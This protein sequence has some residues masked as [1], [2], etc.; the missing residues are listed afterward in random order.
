M[1]T[2]NPVSSTITHQTVEHAVSLAITGAPHVSDGALTIAPTLA[3]LVYRRTN[4]EPVTWTAHLSGPRVL[5]GTPTQDATDVQTV[6]FAPDLGDTP[7]W[8]ADL[9]MQH[10]PADPNMIVAEWVFDAWTAE[11]AG[12]SGEQLTAV[13]AVARAA[14][15]LHE[16]LHAANIDLSPELDTLGDAAAEAAFGRFAE[17]AQGRDAPADL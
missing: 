12:L 6:T 16:R 9:A 10:T 4:R 3:S 14:E 5:G 11:T 17:R 15:N 13:G 1:N 7:Q 2:P 8:V